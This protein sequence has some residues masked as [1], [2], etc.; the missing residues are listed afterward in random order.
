MERKGEGDGRE[1][2]EMNG[3]IWSTQK[4]WCGA[5]YVLS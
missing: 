4:F 2:E 3:E 5:T 1:E